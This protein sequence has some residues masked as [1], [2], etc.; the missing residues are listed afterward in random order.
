MAGRAEGR[1]VAILAA[2][3]FEESELFS[4]KDALDREGATTVVVSLE[5]GEIQANRHREHGRSIK[6][7]KKVSD[8][9]ADDFDALLIPGGLFSPDEIRNDETAVSFVRDFFRQKK[10]VAA[11]CHGPQVLIE[12]DVVKGRKMT[13]VAN[14][15][16]DLK[17]AGANV[18]DEAVVVDE[19]LVTSRTPDDLDA[20]NA[21]LIE[22][23][24]E[25]KHAAQAQSV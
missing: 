1:R 7:D 5:S 20:F 19:G 22:E 15:R 3:G 25:G 12:A 21:K 2:D 13:S 6:V 16:T 14:I 11:I 17:N 23:V 4:P 10:P 18:V 8:V 9:K 24:C